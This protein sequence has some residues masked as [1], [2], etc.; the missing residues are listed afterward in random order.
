M[1]GL[2]LTF[3]PS[4]TAR[5]KQWIGDAL[6]V[7]R[8]PVNNAVFSATVQTVDEPPCPGHSDYMCSVSTG[9][10]SNNIYIRKG[11]EDPSASFNANVADGLDRFFMESF[12]HEYGHLFSFIFTC[13]GDDAITATADWFVLDKTGAGQRHGTL[14]DWTD[15]TV[16]W[17]DRLKEGYAEVFKDVYMLPEHRYFDNRTN[18]KLLREHFGDWLDAIE[19]V[20]CLGGGIS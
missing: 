10:F 13:V 5:Q 16:A 8:F 15:S 18:W 2:D 4:V 1:S 6:S 20:V 14:A 19:N 17:E 7:T 9:R 12:M 11:A 3:D